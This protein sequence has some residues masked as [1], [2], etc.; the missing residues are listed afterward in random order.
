MLRSSADGDTAVLPAEEPRRR[1]RPVWAWAFGVAAVAAVA[2]MAIA[3]KPWRGPAAAEGDG[4]KARRAAVAAAE[5]EPLRVATLEVRHIANVKGE[6]EDRGRIGEDSVWPQW[7]DAVKV[8]VELNEPAYFYLMALN[9]EGTVQPV[10]PPKGERPPKRQKLIYPK[11]KEFRL[12]DP[13]DAGGM[14]AF[15]VA[16]SRDPLPPYEEWEKIAG[17]PTWRRVRPMGGVWEFDGEETV[18]VRRSAERKRGQEKKALLARPPLD[19]LC[20]S[21]RKH[22]VQVTRAVTF[23]VL[24]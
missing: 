7:N 19:E 18:I 11:E 9:F 6:G 24:K 16:A 3:W 17:K 2:A 21:L 22:G 23:P 8:K 5:A 13:A 20:E 10:W 4:G 15:A 12:N 1:R 14:Q